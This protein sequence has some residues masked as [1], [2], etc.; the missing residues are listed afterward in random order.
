MRFTTRFTTERFKAVRRPLAAAL[1][2]LLAA[3][4]LALGTGGASADVLGG[5]AVDPATGAD[6]SGI[7]LT[8]AGQCPQ[9][10]TNLIVTVRGAGF[11]A[12]GQIVV[13]NSPIDIY[14]ATQ[15]GGFAVPLTE[16]MRDYA[17]EAGFT[18]LQGRY[19]FTLTCRM[20]FGSTTY[21][22][23]TAP[24]W[25]T[26]DTTYQST[27]P[28]TVTPTTTKLTASP[29]SPVVQG[30]AVKLTAAVSPATATGT[31]RFLDGTTQLGSPV[32]V[33][34]GTA[35]LSTSSLAVGTHSLKASFTPAD[36]AVYG[37]SVSAALSYTVKIKPPAVVSAAK[38]TGTVRAGSTV[39]CS[40]SFSGATSVSYAWLK[41][42]KVI[43]GQ[44]AKT[45]TLGGAEYKHKIACRATGK[46]TTGSTVSTSPAVTV[47]L[48]PALK[49]GT[50]PSIS[51]THKVGYKQTAKPGS[52]KP[53]ATSYSYVW[54]RDG[55]TISGATKS[56][57]TPTRS[58]RGHK[59]TV[60]VTAKRG[61]YA[62]GSATSVS[63]KIA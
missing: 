49:V 12:E 44:T 22:D 41:D 35:T 26:S 33:S 10:A 17:S 45:R 6:T 40:V 51:G 42:G 8:T 32:T 58:D 47:G 29:A 62:N 24:I 18:T 38:V 19:D 28:V 3:G 13:G 56:T 43:S 59:L 60:T 31:V 25:F 34:G 23:F 14:P 50:K 57:Y 5:M 39:T 54:K 63:V 30:T 36:P 52:W 1:V 61:G 7:L 11:P 48:G 20:P 2:S 21:G 15:N 55:K 9:P 53:A 37:P 4:S 27:E 16:T 46:N